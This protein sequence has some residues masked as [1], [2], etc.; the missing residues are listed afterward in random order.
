MGAKVT[1]VFG[2][3]PV[4]GEFSSKGEWTESYYLITTATPSDILEGLDWGTIRER[5]SLLA[6]GWMIRKV[7]VTNWPSN[8]RG[9]SETVNENIGKGTYP[10]GQETSEQPYDRLVC[11]IY[12]TSGHRRSLFLG[13]ISRSLVDP[14]GNYLAP[15]EFERRFRAWI[16]SIKASSW[17]LQLITPTVKFGIQNVFANNTAMPGSSPYTPAIQVSSDGPLPIT[18]GQKVRISESRGWSYL[19]GEWTADRISNAGDLYT[20]ILRQ[21]RNT[22]VF[23]ATQAPGFIVGLEGVLEQIDR[24]T[25]LFGRAKKTGRPFDLPRGRRSTRR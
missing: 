9:E 6:P 13:G 23:G 3:R 4:G 25:P 14:G 20:I 11:A 16:D 1:F 15:A 5:A 17:A 19:N 8:R 21:K 18:E 7:R 24:G 12:S 10:G 22:Q 2:A